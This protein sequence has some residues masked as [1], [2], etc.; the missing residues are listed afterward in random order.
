[1]NNSYTIK[2]LIQLFLSK[3]WLIIIITVVGA[4]AGFG[5]SKGTGQNKDNMV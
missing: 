5:V 1:M 2:D 3:I 4:A